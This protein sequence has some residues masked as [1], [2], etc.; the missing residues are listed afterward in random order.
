MHPIAADTNGDFGCD[1]AFP[2]SGYDD[3]NCAGGRTVDADVKDRRRPYG[4]DNVDVPDC[5]GI[6]A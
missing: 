2:I 5:V 3:A 1:A 6:V 4:F